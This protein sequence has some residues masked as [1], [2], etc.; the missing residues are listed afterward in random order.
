M[1]SIINKVKNDLINKNILK[2]R[3]IINKY[4]IFI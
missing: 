1:L 2:V 3:G 4:Y